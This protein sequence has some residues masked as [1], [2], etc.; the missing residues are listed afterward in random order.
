MLSLRLSHIFIFCALCVPPCYQAQTSKDILVR[1]YS[2]SQL[3]EDLLL[4]KNV[5]LAMHP[6][7]GIYQ[8]YAYYE[9][10][11]DTAIGSL[12][13]SLT[14]K[15]FRI[16]CK[17]LVEEFHCG[18]TEILGSKAFLKKISKLKLNYSPYIFFPIHN[19]VYVIAN[20]NKKQDS[21]LKKGTEVLKINGIAVDSMLRYCR[22][23]ISAD[24]YNTTAKAHF[25]QLAFNNFY[26]SL[27]G[28]P[29]TVTLDY[30]DG[31][32]VKEHVFKAIKIS[33]IPPLPI[34]SREDSLF[35]RH[36]K[37]G[38][39][40]RY[41]DPGKKTLILKVEK[42]SHRG[43]RRVY[44]KLF[45]Q[46]EKN[47]S[48]NL[49]LDLRNNGGGSI[50]NSYR[51]LS[52]LLDSSKTQTLYTG[53]KNYP[54]K[55]YTRGNLAFRFTRFVFSVIGKKTSK[56][57]TDQFV[58]TIKPR[59]KRQFKGRVFVLINGGS[60]SA[61]CLVAAYLRVQANVL[62]IGEETG[63]A[64]EG[65]NAGVTPYYT[66]PN[67][68]IRLRVPAFR[69]KHDVQPRITAHGILPDYPTDYSFKDFAKRVD[70]DLQKVVELINMPQ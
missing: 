70:L 39:K 13:D 68:K 54:Y 41:L 29:D 20:L 2:P 62:F 53:I 37:A 49:V 21:A 6:A 10:L 34:V 32:Q 23:F 8:P 69:L 55:K 63:G 30:K 51:L 4:F 46:V 1:K 5:T 12:T 24:G 50:G 45:K 28:R 9:N 26:P 31:R 60:F 22:R 16:K 38:I 27:F 48:S 18:H 65:C 58:Y 67:T 43:Y 19:K 33:N 57:D 42:F 15:Q 61:S 14:E 64:A 56:H 3:K 47:K 17:L 66:F 52:Y 44:K 35:T 59:H 11:F 7:I 36:K 25:I 40:Y